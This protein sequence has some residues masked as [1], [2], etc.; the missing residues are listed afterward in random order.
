MSNSLLG[1][2]HTHFLSEPKDIRTYAPLK[3]AY[4]GDAV[5]EIIIR[6]LIIEKTGGPVKNLHKKSSS[7]VNAGTQ[8]GLAAAMQELL[9]E[10]EQTIF[11]QGRNAKTSSVA[12]N[13]DIHDYRNAT[14]L[15]SLFGYLY[16]LGQTDRAIELLKFAM[17]RQNIIL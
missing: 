4:L 11:K 15:E 14:G 6:T 17:K 5:F 9:T 3:L 1:E 12:K 16:L 7:L 13:A 8:A 2:I 10:E